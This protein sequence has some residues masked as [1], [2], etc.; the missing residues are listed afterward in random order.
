MRKSIKAYIY[1][2]IDVHIP[3]SSD[4]FKYAGI[5]VECLLTCGQCLF[6]G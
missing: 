1:R 3:E 5:F 4:T 6:D 2:E